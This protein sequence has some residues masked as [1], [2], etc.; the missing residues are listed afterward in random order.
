[1]LDLVWNGS[2]VLSAAWQ[3]LSVRREGRVPDTQGET[4]PADAASAQI[5]PA[6]ID[7]CDG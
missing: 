2:L 7:R 1:M 3:P 6:L 4:L 5:V